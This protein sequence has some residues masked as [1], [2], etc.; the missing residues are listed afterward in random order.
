M[1]W[2]VNSENRQNKVLDIKFHPRYEGKKKNDGINHHKGDIRREMVKKSF[3]FFLLFYVQC[4]C[5]QSDRFAQR[6][7]CISITNAF[8]SSSLCLSLNMCVCAQF[9]FFLQE[10]FMN[11][12]IRPFGVFLYIFR[13]GV[14]I[15]WCHFNKRNHKQRTNELTVQRLSLSKWTLHT[16]HSLS[17]TQFLIVHGWTKDEKKVL[18]SCT[19]KRAHLLS[20]SCWRLSNSHLAVDKRAKPYTFTSFFIHF[21]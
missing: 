12:V 2:T 11:T 8:Y 13:F 6:L 3:D 5:I 9:F 19:K 14:C 18:A 4:T 20:L 15:I 16:I 7:D 10:R 1:L 17:H 21:F